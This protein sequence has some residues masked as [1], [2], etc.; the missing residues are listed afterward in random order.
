MAVVLAKK[1]GHH[2]ESFYYRWFSVY[3]G[4]DN[5]QY[6]IQAWVKYQCLLKGRYYR[7]GERIEI[8]QKE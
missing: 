8:Q 2:H 4:K 6:I 5:R 3:A 7:G 1:G